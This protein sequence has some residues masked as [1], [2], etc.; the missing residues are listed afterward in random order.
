MQ[1]SDIA[2]LTELKV[3]DL[4][5]VVKK[6]RHMIE[7]AELLIIVYTDHSAVIFIICQTFMNTTLM[8]KLNLQLIHTSKYLQWF[9]LNI[10]YKFSKTNIISDTLS[11]LASCDYQSELNKLSLNALHTSVLSM[12]ANTLV[13]IFSAFWEQIIQDYTEPHW[14]Q[15]I[16][17]IEWNN[18]LNTNA[19]ALSY[20][21]IQNL[22]YYK[23]IE[24]NY[25][26]CILSYLYKN[27]FII[28]HDFMSHSDYVQTHKWLTDS[29]QLSDLLKYL[30]KY[31][32]HC[33]QCQLMQTSWHHLYELMQ[34]IL[35]S[36]QL[37]HILTINFILAL[38]T[39]LSSDNY[40]TI[41]LVTDKFSKI[42]TLIS[43]QKIMMTEDWTI[44]LMNHLILLN[45]GLSRVI[46]LNRNRKFITVLWKEL[47][48]QL[49]INLLFSTVYHS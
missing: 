39:S 20:T 8:K 42:I 45:W 9:C 24:K 15:V 12:Y 25:C 49:Q 27:I 35:T 1:K 40:D 48:K 43:R 19:A 23:D 29:L 28:V 21:W 13:E 34:S 32:W 22:M 47:F 10:H 30:Y 33:S 3:I 44:N 2:I 41:L 38:S 14:K 5:R 4:V 46:L 6:I 7:A 31:F 37:F 18:N 26:L 11:R 17:M 16:D 36:S